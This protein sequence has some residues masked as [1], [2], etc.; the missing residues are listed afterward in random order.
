MARTQ[1]DRPLLIWEPRGGPERRWTYREFN[2][3]VAVIAAGLHA[4]GVKKGDKVLIHSEN[5]PEM[6]LAW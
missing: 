2:D 3:E 6:V 1:P 4:R 5:C